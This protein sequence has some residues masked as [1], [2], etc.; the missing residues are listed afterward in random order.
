M[1]ENDE[2]D[3][4]KTFTKRKKC[5]IIMWVIATLQILCNE[6]PNLPGCHCQSRMELTKYDHVTTKSCSQNYT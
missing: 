5:L 3:K 1:K 6:T 2:Y 4:D